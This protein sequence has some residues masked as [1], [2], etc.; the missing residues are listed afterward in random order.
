MGGKNPRRRKLTGRQKILY[1]DMNSPIKEGKINQVEKQQFLD[2]F[3]LK[4]EQEKKQRLILI[5]VIV[6]C[7][8]IGV[9]LLFFTSPN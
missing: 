7:G 4:K 6:A 5:I 1:S 2:G 8:V 3:R 9:S